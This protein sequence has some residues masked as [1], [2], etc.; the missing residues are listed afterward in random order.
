MAKKTI[1]ILTQVIDRI[2]AVDVFD[3]KDEA[4][5]T[6]HKLF[7]DVL[8]K[9]GLTHEDED[10]YEISS[11]GSAWINDYNGNLYDWDITKK[12]ISV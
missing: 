6:M 8:E 10:R 12:T 11:K 7:S 1:Y 4:L 5:E 2:I 3:T 9:Q